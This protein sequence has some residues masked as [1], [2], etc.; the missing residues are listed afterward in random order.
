M[1]NSILPNDGK[2]LAKE[3]E[4]LP[5]LKPAQLAERW[6]VLYGAQ[7]PPRLR[8]GLM[9]R[10]LAYRLQE[11]VLGGLKPATRRLLKTAAGAASQRRPIA[12]HPRPSA[13]TGT[14]FVREWHGT[15]HQVTAVRDGFMFHGKRFRSL[16]K[17]AREI[18]GTHW[19]GPL[20]FGLRRSGK[21]HQDGAR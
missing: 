17:I 1:K 15:K 9:I 12:G 7:P 20:F 14:V 8:R 11:Q 21:E 18:T 5:S 10:A 19:S 3:L 13:Q 2:G 16:S 6:R 4:R